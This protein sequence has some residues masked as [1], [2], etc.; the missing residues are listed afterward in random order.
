MVV[1]KS[2]YA[3]VCDKFA[4]VKSMINEKRER[5]D[6]EVDK[7]VT[8]IALPNSKWFVTNPDIPCCT[9]VELNKDYYES[10][11]K[12]IKTAPNSKDGMIIAYCND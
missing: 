12:V 7:H 5:G 3:D 4:H 8:Y 6:A 9:M 1:A 11:E 10:S 2:A